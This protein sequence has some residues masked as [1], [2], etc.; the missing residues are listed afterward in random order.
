MI[1]LQLVKTYIACWTS[2]FRLLIYLRSEVCPSQQ[3]LVSPTKPHTCTHTNTH[4]DKTGSSCKWKLLLKKNKL[5]ILS[6]T[7]LPRSETK[8]RCSIHNNKYLKVNSVY[9][10]NIYLQHTLSHFLLALRCHVMSFCLSKQILNL[11]QRMPVAL[12][13]ILCLT[14]D[15]HRHLYNDD[16]RM[17]R[18]AFTEWPHVT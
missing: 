3:G 13:M 7:P 1:G 12:R 2:N 15:R 8:G 14:K 5:N 9:M 11:T 10:D 18:L 16:S 17:L 4:R 6:L